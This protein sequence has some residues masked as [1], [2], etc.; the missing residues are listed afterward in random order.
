MSNGP[1]TLYKL[2]SSLAKVVCEVQGR[3]GKSYDMPDG[4]IHPQALRIH[5]RLIAKVE[6]VRRHQPAVLPIFASSFLTS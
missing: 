1:Y 3:L 6:N 4:T 5:A 2:S